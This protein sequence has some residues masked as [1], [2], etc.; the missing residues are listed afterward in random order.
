MRAAVKASGLEHQE[1]A[2]KMG[3]DPV[4]LSR[5]VNGH[6]EPRAKS[7]IRFVRATK[8]DGHWLLTGKAR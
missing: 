7:L 6:R 2:W 5:Y 3:I 1:V 8:C 4:S